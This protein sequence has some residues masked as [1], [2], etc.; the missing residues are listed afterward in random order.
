MISFTLR[1]STFFYFTTSDRAR[2]RARL[3][4]CAAHFQTALQLPPACARVTLQVRQ[5]NAA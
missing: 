4:L 3:L 5:G 2:R 1:K